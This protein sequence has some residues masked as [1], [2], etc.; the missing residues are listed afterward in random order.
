MPSGRLFA[1]S[2]LSL[3]PLSRIYRVTPL[4]HIYSISPMYTVQYLLAPTSLIFILR[5]WYPLIINAVQ[6]LQMLNVPY[7]TAQY[8]T[9]LYIQNSKLRTTCCIESV[10]H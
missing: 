8:S 3:S 1:M 2:H 7:K 5:T 4:S 10:L 6:I 9:V